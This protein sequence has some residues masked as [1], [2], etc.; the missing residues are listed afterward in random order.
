MAIGFL[1][2]IVTSLCQLAQYNNP[3]A[4]ERSQVVGEMQRLSASGERERYPTNI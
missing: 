3:A 2:L 1:T 4:P